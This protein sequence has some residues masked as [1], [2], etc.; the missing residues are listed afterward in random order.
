MGATKEAQRLITQI[1][2]LGTRA[3]L[4]PNNIQPPCIVVMPDGFRF[5]HLGN[6]CVTFKYRVMCVAPAVKFA[7]SLPVLDS[8]IDVLRQ[9]DELT[10]SEVEP[11]SVPFGEGSLPAYLIAVEHD[12]SWT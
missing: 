11:S 2:D 8:L 9:V 3:T 10:F 6:D 5:D 4:D 7:D 1:V 12:G